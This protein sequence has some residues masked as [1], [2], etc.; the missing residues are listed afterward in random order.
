MKTAI[1]LMALAL[2]AIGV[3]GC[4]STN[5]YESSGGLGT[6]YDVEMGEGRAPLVES[7]ATPT[8]PEGQYFLWKNKGI[9][10]TTP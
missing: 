5:T 2:M 9:T 6:N 10:P 4:R 8:Y 7:N 3:A 1:F